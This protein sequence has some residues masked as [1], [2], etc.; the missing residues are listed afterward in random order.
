MR[1]VKS[2]G[3]NSHFCRK[4]SY[5]GVC[6]ILIFELKYFLHLDMKRIH[7][8]LFLATLGFSCSPEL[9]DPYAS[10]GS[11]IKI[12]LREE[13]KEDGKGLMIIS[14]TLEIFPCYNYFLITTESVQS[15]E[16]TMT[17]SGISKPEICLT[18]LGPARSQEYF[19]LENGIYAITF[20]NGGISN[21]GQL[22]VDDDKYI[23]ELDHPTNV[24]VENEILRRTL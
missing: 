10:V 24:F 14:E 6:K 19:N 15:E 7:L 20:I 8:V 17:Y 5:P 23:L 2:G 12:T 4:D 22:T 21:E 9:A 3:G 11:D 18:A 16:I 1:R 13:I